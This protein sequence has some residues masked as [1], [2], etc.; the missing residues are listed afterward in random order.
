MFRVS[1]EYRISE[2]Q[3]DLIFKT[4]EALIKWVNEKAP[5]KLW[6]IFEDEENPEIPINF[7][8]LKEHGLI[9]IRTA[10]IIE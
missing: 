9:E 10:I 4:E 5:A 1:S 2:D 8:T 7:E 6:D 3:E